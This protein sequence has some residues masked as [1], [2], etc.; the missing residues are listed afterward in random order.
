MYFLI[1]FSFKYWKNSI[2][3]WIECLFLIK[4]NYNCLIEIKNCFAF[5]KVDFISILDNNYLII[6]NI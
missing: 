1:N 3:F 5:N 2:M 4:I 6:I